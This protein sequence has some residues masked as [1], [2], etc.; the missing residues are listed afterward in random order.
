MVYEC[1]WRLGKT[2]RTSLA[3]NSRN[4]DTL[5]DWHYMQCIAL[6]EMHPRDLPS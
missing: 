1:D 5:P 3:Q 4:T 6:D 2:G